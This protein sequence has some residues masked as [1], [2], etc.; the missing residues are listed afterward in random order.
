MT[1]KRRLL[2]GT[3]LALRRAG[4]RLERVPASVPAVEPTATQ[5][6]EWAEQVATERCITERHNS[7]TLG[8]VRRLSE[9]YSK[10]IFGE[11]E[12]W[13]VLTM[14]GTCL[15]PTDGA[16]GAASQLVH[17]LQVLEMMISEGVTDEDLFLAALLHDLGKV[18]LLTDEDPANVV[19]MNRF[20]SGEPGGGL[21][22]G[23]T[24]WNHDEFAF[25][26]LEGVVPNEVA[27]LIR[28]HSVMPADLEPFLVPSERRFADRYHRTFFR[29]DQESKSAV[30]R[31]RLRLE[32]FRSLV[33]RRLPAR[34]EI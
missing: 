34:L 31:P 3:N 18:L 5:R 7:Q 2:D 17:V 4:V 25:T 32:D 26:R 33:V 29:Y 28:Y 21:Q 8:D 9:K 15:D 22:Q 23:T 19:C 10:P 12:T 11:V 13:D 27:L 20:I 24:Q 14:L 30:R 1:V 16:L 6:R